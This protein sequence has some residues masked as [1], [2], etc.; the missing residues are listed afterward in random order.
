MAKRTGKTLKKETLLSVL[1]RDPE[2]YHGAVNIPVYHASTI[3]YPSFAALK[4][5][6]QREYGKV[7][8]GRHG[9]PTTFALQDTVAEI[10]GGWRS[11]AFGSG[12]D[13]EVVAERFAGLVAGFVV[14]GAVLVNGNADGVRAMVEQGT[15]A[16]QVEGE[17]FLARQSADD[18]GIVPRF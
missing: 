6:G 12:K 14:E 1:G 10:E 16:T 11:F 2:A 7:F 5:A 13:R 9:T 4:K 15:K 3:L 8:Y 17:V 18:D